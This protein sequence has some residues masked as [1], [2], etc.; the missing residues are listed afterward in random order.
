MILDRYV[1]RWRKKLC[2]NC[3]VGL[4]WGRFCWDCVRAWA[5]GAAT[6]LGGWAVK[7]WL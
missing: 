6:A 1:N 4:L 3:G 5:V 7:R 2:L